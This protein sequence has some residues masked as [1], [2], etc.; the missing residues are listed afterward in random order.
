MAKS[1]ENIRAAAVV[2][3]R[4]VQGLGENGVDVELAHVPAFLLHASGG[5][6]HLFHLHDVD[7]A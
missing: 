5:A 1:R 6:H 4:G 3:H 2:L 7:Y